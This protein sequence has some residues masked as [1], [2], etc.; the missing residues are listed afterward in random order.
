M[1]EAA[2]QVDPA[3]RAAQLVR[4]QGPVAYVVHRGEAAARQALVLCRGLRQRGV[5]VEQDATGSAFAKQF[6]RA[7]RSGADWALVLGDAE[8]ERGVVKLKPLQAAVGE[9]A[10][11]ELPVTDFDRL[12][13]CLGQ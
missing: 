9:T 5:A 7:D 2:A 10:P 4:A 3:G 8:V 13:L 12:A 11:E 6:K 1:L